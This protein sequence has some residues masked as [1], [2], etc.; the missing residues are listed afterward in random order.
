MTHIRAD[1]VVASALA[2]SDQGVG[3]ADNARRHGVA[4]KTIRRWRRLYQRRG[5]P[6]GQAHTRALCPRCDDVPLA[7]A[8]F[9]ELFGWYLGDGWLESSPRDV[10]TLH[11]YNDAAYPVLNAGLA[12]LMRE[13][14]PGGRP[15]Q[16]GRPGLC[17]TSMGWKHWPCLLPQHGPG[18]KHERVLP[19]EDWQWQVVERHPDA[20]LRGL[21]HSDGARVANW[22][23]RTVA[24]RT[25]RYEYPRWQFVN[26]S[27][28]ILGWCTDA[29]DLVDV[30]WRRSG[31][32]T[33]SV[34]T[35]EGVARL[36]ELVGPKS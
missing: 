16:R 29:L 32:W 9:A 33:V 14:K 19:M 8:A 12:A 15:H 35:R 13:V 6:R 3:D 21:L 1:E 20:F 34:S 2:A 31:R 5:L 24:G 22:A 17:T 25:K 28:Q 26:R 27:E 23:T 18:R 7:E 36:D 30:P 4:V 11:I 10:F